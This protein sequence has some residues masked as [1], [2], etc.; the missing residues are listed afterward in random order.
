MIVEYIVENKKKMLI[1]LLF[2]VILTVISFY[3]NNQNDMKVYLSDDYIYTKETYEHSTGLVSKLPYINI[4]DEEINEVNLELIKKYYEVITI[5]KQMMEYVYYE[6]NNILS[7]VVSIFYQEAPDSP[8]EMLFYNVDLDTG[9][10]IDDSELVEVFNTSADEISA[11]INDELK[12]YYD[13]EIEKGYITNDC[14]FEC[15][16]S[17]VGALLILDNCNSYVKDNYL[18][19]HK[20]LLLNS[21]FFYDSD[22]G[23]DLFNFKVKER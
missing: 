9:T 15:Y 10:L 1:L 5:D 21:E 8:S 18:Y 3:M 2:V 13:Y 6:N 23:F 12:E 4:K 7:L 20:E 16:L 17:R 14:N 22:S 11:T 19:V